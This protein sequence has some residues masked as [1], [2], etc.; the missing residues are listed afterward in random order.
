[1][2]VS[3]TPYIPSFIRSFNRYYL[4][5]RYNKD[6]INYKGTDVIRPPYFKIPNNKFLSLN[7]KNLSKSIDSCILEPE[8]ISLIHA[9]FGQNGVGA[10]RLKNKIKVP[11]I[12]SFYGYDSGRLGYL[13]KPFYHELIQ[14]GDIFLALSQDMKKD[15][16]DLG[17]PNEKIIIHHLGIDLEKFKPVLNNR[18][19]KFSYLIVA[20]FDKS[21]GIQDVMRAFSKMNKPNIELII[22]GDGPYKNELI[23][24][25]KKLCIDNKVRFINNFKFS[26]S[27]QIVIDEMKKCDVFL[28]TSFMDNSGAKEGT[29]VVLMEAQAC[30]KPCIATRHAG[31]PEVVIHDKTGFLVDER[32]V[33]SIAKKM[34]VFY[35]DNELLSKMGRRAYLHIKN[36]FN[37][38]KQMNELINIYRKINT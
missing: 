21:K 5:P 31:I 28:L 20:R 26:N 37:S 18:K 11:L 4:Y 38:K 2:V 17:F 1:M 35:D 29:P 15:L 24:I 34:E 16:L 27:R 8:S 32:D 36:N 23:E 12:T 22:I 10:L 6:I 19:K 9:H 14:K 30:G 13:F 7:L 3:P 33:Q 25:S